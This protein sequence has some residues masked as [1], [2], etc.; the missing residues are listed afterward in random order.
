MNTMVATPAARA[1]VSRNLAIETVQAMY[2]DSMEQAVVRYIIL[3]LKRGE[4]RARTV[5]VTNPQQLIPTLIFDFTTES[6][7]STM[8]S[9]SLR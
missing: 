2:T 5:P 9:K 1:P 4:V 3:R 6:L 7:T 8:S